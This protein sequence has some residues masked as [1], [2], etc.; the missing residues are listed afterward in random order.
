M[1]TSLA[2]QSQTRDASDQAKAAVYN[3]GALLVC[4]H[5]LTASTPALNTRPNNPCL[6]ATT[7][8]HTLRQRP[9]R[10]H[11]RHQQGA[12]SSLHCWAMPMTAAQHAHCPANTPTSSPSRAAEKRCARV[13]AARARQRGAGWGLEMRKGFTAVHAA[14]GVRWGLQGST[15]TSACEF[16]QAQPAARAST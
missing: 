14:S 12:F 8:W 4:V 15:C 6:T 13:R 10:K 2:P 5:A 9:P 3:Q 11:M 7:A 16:M 1:C